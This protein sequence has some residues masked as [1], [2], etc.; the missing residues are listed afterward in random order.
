MSTKA[1]VRHFGA[2]ASVL[3]GGFVGLLLA[4]D[5]GDYVPRLLVVL[6]GAVWLAISWRTYTQRGE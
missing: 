4:D 3:L 6:I 1:T 5:A 2:G